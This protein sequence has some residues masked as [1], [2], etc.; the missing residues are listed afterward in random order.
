MLRINCVIFV[1]QL[2]FIVIFAVLTIFV[3]FVNFVIFVRA[4]LNVGNKFRKFRQ[5]SCDVTAIFRSYCSLEIS[6]VFRQ[7]FNPRHRCPCLSR[8]AFFLP[9]CFFCQFISGIQATFK[10]LLMI[11]KSVILSPPCFFSPII[12]NFLIFRGV[13]S[14]KKLKIIELI[15][16]ISCSGMTST[17]AL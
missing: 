5:P 10:A 4:F 15:S 16:L 13:P 3:I 9:R 7:R 1:K 6:R 11:L 12:V 8:V 14:Q 17:D 2:R